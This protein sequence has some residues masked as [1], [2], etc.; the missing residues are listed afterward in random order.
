MQ[1]CADL[2][3]RLTSRPRTAD[4]LDHGPPK[5]GLAAFVS[6]KSERVRAGQ[7]VALMYGIFVIDDSSLSRPDREGGVLVWRPAYPVQPDYLSW[8][9]V[10]GSDGMPLPYDGPIVDGLPWGLDSSIRLRER[11]FYGGCS[12][13][14]SLQYDLTKPGIYSVKWIYSPSPTFAKGPWIG[15]LESNEIKIEVVP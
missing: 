7:P 14:I 15:R 10:S 13:E 6:A 8:F 1:T 11:S 5:D 2:A 3:R 12:G 9:V 4:L